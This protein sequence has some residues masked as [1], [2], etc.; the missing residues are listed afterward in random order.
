MKNTHARTQTAFV[1]WQGETHGDASRGGG[2]KHVRR[3]FQAQYCHTPKVCTWYTIPNTTDSSTPPPLP[4]AVQLFFIQGMPPRLFHWNVP[5]PKHEPSKRAMRHST[6]QTILTDT[7][8]VRLTPPAPAPSFSFPFVQR[9]TVRFK[10]R[11]GAILLGELSGRLSCQGGITTAVCSV[12]P[13][14]LATDEIVGKVSLKNSFLV[15]SGMPGP[16]FFSGLLTGQINTHGS[17]RVG[18]TRPDP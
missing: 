10:K 1:R 11:R 9:M 16:F 13:L 8:S 3:K 6:S 18:L 17:G 15:R 5:C 4:Y 14:S 7:P 12:R 2:A